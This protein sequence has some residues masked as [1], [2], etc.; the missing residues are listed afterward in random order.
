MSVSKEEFEIPDWI[1]HHLN[2]YGNCCCGRDIVKKIGKD[3]IIEILRG[4][5]YY[6]VLRIVYDKHRKYINRVKY[7]IDAYYILEIECEIKTYYLL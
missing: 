1:L 7:P 4:K 2:K 3:R 6:C 5:G